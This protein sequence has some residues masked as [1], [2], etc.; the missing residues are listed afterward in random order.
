MTRTD[1]AAPHQPAFSAPLFAEFDL[2]LLDPAGHVVPL[3]VGSM[4]ETRREPTWPDST[5]DPR[6]LALFLQRNVEGEPIREDKRHLIRR[7]E[8]E[9]RRQIGRAHV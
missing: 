7:L 1:K 3:D 2:G 6:S 8:E 5:R 4:V 9:M